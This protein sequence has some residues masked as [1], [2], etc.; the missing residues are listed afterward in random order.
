LAFTF[1]AAAIWYQS[2]VNFADRSI[3]ECRPSCC[4]SLLQMPSSRWCISLCHHNQV[5]STKQIKEKNSLA[6]VYIVELCY[7]WTS[8]RM[9]KRI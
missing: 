8:S 2:H 6:K 1:F 4:T 5:T 7:L 3:N 9:R